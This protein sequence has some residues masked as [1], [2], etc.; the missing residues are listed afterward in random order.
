VF[1][2]VNDCLAPKLSGDDYEKRIERDSPL[3]QKMFEK[4]KP[5]T[6]AKPP[7]KASSRNPERQTRRLQGAAVTQL[8]KDGTAPDARNWFVSFLIPR[9]V[10]LPVIRAEL[11]RTEAKSKSLQK[12]TKATK[13]SLLGPSACP[14]R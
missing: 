7:I 12:T 4:L 8:K 1:G 3:V 10:R 13:G 9:F 6:I 11:F 2:A 5:N 14:S